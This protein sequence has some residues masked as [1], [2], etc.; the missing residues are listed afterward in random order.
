MVDKNVAGEQPLEG[1]VVRG[2]IDGR[3]SVARWADGALDAEPELL[4]RAEV[5]VAMGDYFPSEDDPGHVVMASLDGG[6]YD[7]MLTIMRAF[8]HV[9]SVELPLGDSA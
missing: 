8:T 5:I 7:V 9:T 2:V 6:G 3:P 4:R 1:F